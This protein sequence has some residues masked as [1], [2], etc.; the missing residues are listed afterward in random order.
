MG[1]RT[2]KVEYLTINDERIERGDPRV[3]YWRIYLYWSALLHSLN[4]K[5][6]LKQTLEK[7]WKTEELFHAFTAGIFDTE[8]YFVTKYNKPERIGI[9]QSK[10]K[11]WFYPFCRKLQEKYDININDRKRNYC[12]NQ[13][14][15][16]YKGI[17]DNYLVYIKTRSWEEFINNLLVYTNKELYHQRA[18]WFKDRALKIKRK[19]KR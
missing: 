7:I 15:K 1:N 9:E 10:K 8:G 3:K 2:V 18:E 5:K 17:S 11:W 13:R 4:N 16:I 12:I 19:E 14:G 6:I